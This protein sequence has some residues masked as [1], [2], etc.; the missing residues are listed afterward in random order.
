MADWHGGFSLFAVKKSVAPRGD[1]ISVSVFQ[2]TA[3]PCRVNFREIRGPGVRMHKMK[4]SPENQTPDG[5]FTACAGFSGLF[6][7]IFQF[8]FVQNRWLLS[9]GNEQRKKFF[10]IFSV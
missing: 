7:L 5:T 9:K 2:S 1:K 4:I 3:P 10:E 6:S 8:S